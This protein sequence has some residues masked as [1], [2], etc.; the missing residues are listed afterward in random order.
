MTEK[1]MKK[2]P[3]GISTLKQILTGNYIYIDKT[4]LAAKL[5]EEYKYVFLSR[6]RRFGKSLFLDTLKELF[7]GN[8]KL[9]TGLAA[10]SLHDWSTTF[11]VIKI[12][13]GN[14]DFSSEENILRS[15]AEQLKNNEERLSLPYEDVIPALRLGRLIHNARKK[16]DVPVVVLIDEYDKPILDNIDSKELAAKARDTLRAFYTTLKE[17][18]AYIRFAF[19]TGVSKF[20]KVSIFSGLN[21]LR[22]ISL[23]PKYGA[24]CGYTHDELQNT[25]STYLS[26][27]DLAELRRWYDGYNFLGENVYNPFDILLFFDND[28]QFSSYWFETGTPTMLV[29]MIQEKRFFLPELSGLK[30]GEELLTS[31]DIE[32]LDII[33]LLFQSGYLTIKKVE[34]FGTLREYSLN[35]PNLEVQ[36][37]FNGALLSIFVHERRKHISLQ[38]SAYRALFSVDLDQ[39]HTAITSLF[40]VIPY[41]NFSNNEIARYEGF[42]ASVVYA[43]LASSQMQVKVEDCTN[44]GRIDMTILLDNAIY[45]LEFKV[46]LAGSAL[47]QIKEQQYAD[48]YRAAGVPIYLVGISFD[49][50]KRNI[51]EFEWEKEQE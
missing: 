23:L 32:H 6:P 28:K 34:Q 20:S 48:K 42:Y 43:W 21:N 47:A 37:A 26:G 8:R 50:E 16:W 3:I 39:F 1:K 12:S 31:F 5:A 27:V 18:D 38:V 24:I 46:D 29:K 36:T 30:A 17:N 35:F 40:A 15:L 13:L 33:T 10:D 7:E 2:L 9:F 19:L 25:F 51:S 45:I 4:A 44:K 11:P 14:G 41:H 22:D 49:S